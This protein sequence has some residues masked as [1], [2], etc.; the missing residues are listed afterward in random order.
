MSKVSLV[1][2]LCKYISICEYLFKQIRFLFII[3]CLK[4]FFFNFY[5]KN[6][7]TKNDVAAVTVSLKITN[8]YFI[9]SKSGNQHMILHFQFFCLKQTVFTASLR[10]QLRCKTLSVRIINNNW[11]YRQCRSNSNARTKL[12]YD[13]TRTNTAAIVTRKA[14]FTTPFV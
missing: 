7:Y 12:L 9:S 5:E 11:Q 4:R 8:I 2:H 6:M 13:A 3:M 10:Y 14:E 1:S